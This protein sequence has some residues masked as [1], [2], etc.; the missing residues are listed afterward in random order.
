MERAVLCGV[1]PGTRRQGREEREHCKLAS[2]TK[3]EFHEIMASVDLMLDKMK[4][5]LKTN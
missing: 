3:P 5:K 4:R 1:K 2:L